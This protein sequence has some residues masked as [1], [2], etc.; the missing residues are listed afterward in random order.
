V[1]ASLPQI[2]VFATE[3]D[4]DVT[5]HKSTN[6]SPGI[7]RAV[8]DPCTTY[9]HLLGAD[10]CVSVYSANDHC[11]NL[12]KAPNG[13]I[14]ASKD[15]GATDEYIKVSEAFESVSTV[16]CDSACEQTPGCTG[17]FC[18]P[19]DHCHG[20]FW[21]SKELSSYCFHSDDQ[22]CNPHVPLLCTVEQNQ[23]TS[24]PQEVS[25]GSNTMIA[26]GL[27]SETGPTTTLQT[28][29]K[30]LSIVPSTP[31][32]ASADST[33]SPEAQS[34]GATNQTLSSKS[35]KKLSILGLGFVVLLNALANF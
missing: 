16:S 17:S 10:N 30:M 13:L 5:T 9:C 24:K 7:E 18:K 8:V 1:I 19:N 23:T 32:D 21:E 6:H 14:V 22:A 33:P 26:E 29:S 35:A 11:V 28:T 15:S 2:S 12:I 3:T 34:L 4:A 20:L 25:T 31:F 27:N